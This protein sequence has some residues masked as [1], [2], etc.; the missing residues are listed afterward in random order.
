MNTNN[1]EGNTEIP[2]VA[3]LV[4]EDGDDAETIKQ[5]VEEHNA[6]VR[7]FKTKKD[8]S[9]AQLFAR[10]KKA[11]GFTLKDNK[12]VKETKPTEENSGKSSQDSLSQADLI[13][14]AR[15][16]IPDEDLPEVLEYTKLKGI[17]VSEALKS[18]VV[19]T[20]LAEKDE[21]RKV[22]EGTNTGNARRG[23]AK[24]SDEQLIANA[25]AGK[26]PESDEEIKR[27]ITLR[28]KK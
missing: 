8:E 25:D 17:T 7:E 22:A 26:M 9:N 24:L 11:E 3:D 18:T 15:S 12:W 20:I 16:N 27:L 28:K 10:T 14:I 1:G 23:S 2:E 13:T 19:K 21:A 6:Q 5:K 4:I